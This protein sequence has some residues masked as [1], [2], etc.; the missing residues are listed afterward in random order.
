MR[1]FIF[2]YT[3]L[4]ITLTSIGQAN[5][6]WTI[7]WN[8]DTTLRGFKD[9][10]GVVKMTP[11]FAGLTIAQKWDDIVAVTEQQNEKGFNYYLTKKGQIFGRDSLYIFD[12]GFDCESE[13]FIRFRDYKN[14]KV[15]LF[16]KNGEVVVPAVYNDLSN[17]RNGLIIALTGAEKKEIGEHST[18]TGGKVLLIDTGNHLLID[19]FKYDSNLNFYSLRV[20]SQADRDTIRKNFSG[21]DGKFY[22]FL[23][24]DKEFRAWVKNSLLNNFSKDGLLNSSYKEITFWKDN[25]G[26]TNESKRSFI[27]RNF[28]LIKSKLLALQSKDCTYDI[29]DD[30]LNPFIFESVEWSLYFDNCGQSK[31][32][33]Y[34]IKDIVITKKIKNDLLQDHFGFLRTPTGYKL[35]TMTIRNA[36]LK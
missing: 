12:N 30:S 36:A 17:V 19:S 22:S 26:W 20:S 21:V 35:L 24:T 27:E 6:T 13:G 32:W 25:I 3:L 16:N 7:F 9:V 5:D 8:Q 23:D 15:G 29:F 1:K 18:W 11:K 14:D 33:L 31:D 4:L 2:I 34:P 28:D 10:N